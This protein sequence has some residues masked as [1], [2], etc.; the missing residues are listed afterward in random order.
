LLELLLLSSVQ[1]G[2]AAILIAGL[3]L[4][5][6]GLAVIRMNL[7]PL[8]FM[9]IHGLLLGGALGLALSLNPLFT[10]LIV[11]IIL[12]CLMLLSTRKSQSNFGY[13]GALFMAF[14]AALASWIIYRFKVPARETQFLLWGSPF[15]ISPGELYS[16]LVFSL[17]L[18]ILR[19]RF[20]RG[21]NA[22]FF[23]AELAASSG[24]REGLYTWTV[25]IFTAVIVSFAMRI[26]GALLMDLL[27]LMPALAAGWIFKSFKQVS[28]GASMLGLILSVLGFTTALLLDI[29]LSTALALPV[30]LL[31]IILLLIKRRF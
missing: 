8:R 17:L 24:L 25:V 3:I 30:M 11:N 12:V 29:P 22:V 18:I 16:F 5:Q 13:M 31:M 15:S 6:A 2:L 26:L 19:I 4:P 10:A 28:I 14:S 20:H 21:L 9:L 27:I 7:L 1:R 23:H